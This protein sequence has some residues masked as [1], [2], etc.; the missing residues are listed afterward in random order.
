MGS[1]LVRAFLIVLLV[2][3]P[4]T[5]V[6][7]WVYEL[8]PEGPRVDEDGVSDA[9]PGAER[10]LDRIII[11][12]LAA[13]I[14]VLLVERFYISQAVTA[15]D[16]Q[17][18]AVLPFA[19]MSDDSDHFA[20]GLSEELLNQLAKM[21]GLKVVGRTSSFAFKGRNED[22]REI[23][24]ALDVDHILEGSVRRSG[25]QL[26]ITAQL[27]KVDDGFH[28]W[29]ETYDRP[30]VDVFEIQ[31]DVSIQIADALQLRLMPNRERPTTSADA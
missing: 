11:G 5:L 14:A 16:T 3:F 4:I 25:N 9:A 6:I 21:P 29:S 15:V 18:I 31:D 20:D 13:A 1:Q 26:R 10:R 7:A 2:G 22:L 8:T 23:G 12:V 28:L 17:S 19:N 24:T 30:L 27:I